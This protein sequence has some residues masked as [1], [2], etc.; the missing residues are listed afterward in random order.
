MLWCDT[1]DMG[2]DPMTKGS[3]GRGLVLG[4]MTGHA[5]DIHPTVRFSDEKRKKSA[6]SSQHSRLNNKP[7]A[8][9]ETDGAAQPER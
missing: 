5:S 3:I 1:P 4:V 7:S 8:G 9:T 6:P 2:A